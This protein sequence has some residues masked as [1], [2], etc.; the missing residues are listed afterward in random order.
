MAGWFFPCATSVGI[1]H[2]PSRC[3]RSLGPSNFL[4]QALPC[5]LCGTWSSDHCPSISGPSCVCSWVRLITH[6]QQ[7]F[8]AL[9]L[10]G[11]RPPVLWCW[12]DSLGWAGPVESP[13]PQGPA[14]G[15]AVFVLENKGLLGRS[16][17]QSQSCVLCS[18]RL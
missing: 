14:Q 8:P 3:Q 16:L 11:Q 5:L 6:L 15:W 13:H 1:V 2:I 4:V 10:A 9:S 12:R 7:M 17:S 18:K